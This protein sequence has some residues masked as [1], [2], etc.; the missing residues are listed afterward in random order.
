MDCDRGCIELSMVA[1]IGKFSDAAYGMKKT[2][3]SKGQ[4]SGPSKERPEGIQVV[5]KWKSTAG[6]CAKEWAF[7]S[8][9]FEDL[10]SVWMKAA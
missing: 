2:S 5:I 7:A 4:Q 3:Q 8:C 1:G 10:G 9:T 6:R